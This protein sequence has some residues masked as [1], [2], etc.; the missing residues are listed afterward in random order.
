MR[1][2]KVDIEKKYSI[3]IEKNKSKYEIVG[4]NDRLFNTLSEI[5]EYLECS[6]KNAQV[7]IEEKKASYGRF[8]LILLNNKPLKVDPLPIAFLN[9]I[10]GLIDFT[11]VKNHHN[12]LSINIEEKIELVTPYV[13][14]NRQH[15]KL[16]TYE[17][18]TKIGD[19]GTAREEIT[20]IEQK[21]IKLDR[22]LSVYC[23]GAKFK[24][25]IIVDKYD[26]VNLYRKEVKQ[27]TK[28]LPP[29]VH[30]EVI[31]KVNQLIHFKHDRSVVY[32]YK[33]IDYQ[34]WLDKGQLFLSINNEKIPHSIADFKILSI[35]S[36]EFNYHKVGSIVNDKNKNL[37]MGKVKILLQN[38]EY[39]TLYN[40][41]NN[42]Y[43]KGYQKKLDDKGNI[44]HLE[45]IF[46]YGSCYFER[47]VIQNTNIYCYPQK[48]DL[49]QYIGYFIKTLEGID[50]NLEGQIMDNEDLLFSDI[51]EKEKIKLRQKI[52]YLESEQLKI[53]NDIKKF[54]SI[55]IKDL[56]H[57]TRKFTKDITNIDN[58]KSLN[59]SNGSEYQ[60]TLK[61]TNVNKRLSVKNSNTGTINKVS[62][63]KVE[64]LALRFIQLLDQNNL[65]I[66]DRVYGFNYFRITIYR[67]DFNN[68]FKDKINMKKSQID[69]KILKTF[70]D[71]MLMLI[72]DHFSLST[73]KPLIYPSSVSTIDKW[74]EK[75]N[76]YLAQYGI[77][78]VELTP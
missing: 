71:F 51:S 42:T 6:L 70:D 9:Q 60:E 52:K 3:T 24:E 4:I 12:V 53:D 76:Q 47:K 31:A 5:V 34:I 17:Y 69:Y 67:D 10:Y 14:D 68:P 22:V 1:F 66:D 72:M 73:N 8:K 18:K 77:E 75:N 62:I 28:V 20:R 55:T 16:K 2:K 29:M 78:I 59:K 46:D 38:K 23:Y 49:M 11:K 7:T 33:G 65:V 15:T 43:V 25:K 61:I 45:I 57:V 63:K 40:Y 39:S 13:Y 21:V 74:L 64:K 48:S 56:N 58:V 54:K 44:T 30:K 37:T 35:P 27:D 32:P 41:L 19:H 36:Y 26:I 50:I